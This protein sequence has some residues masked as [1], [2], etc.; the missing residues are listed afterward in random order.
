MDIIHLNTKLV[1]KICAR[2]FSKKISSYILNC[3][4]TK[5]V[6]TEH[7][8][9]ALSHIGKGEPSNSDLELD[10]LMAINLF[11]LSEMLQMKFKISIH[12][13]L[14]HKYESN[15]RHKNVPDVSVF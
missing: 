12:H 5:T 7:T 8:L 10:L 15:K 14:H 11:L 9:K 2:S 3:L 4:G 1:Q 6:I 13:S